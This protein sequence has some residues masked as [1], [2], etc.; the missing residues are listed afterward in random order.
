MSKLKQALRAH[1]RTLRRSSELHVSHFMVA[2]GESD[3]DAV[4]AALDLLAAEGT[5]RRRPWVECPR[6]GTAVSSDPDDIP[7]RCACGEPLTRENVTVHPTYSAPPQDHRLLSPEDGAGPGLDRL[8]A[9]ALGRTPCDGWEAVTLGGHGGPALQAVTCFHEEGACWPVREHMGLGGLPKYSTDRT[10]LSLA[11]LPADSTLRFDGHR[12]HVRVPGCVEVS[13]AT[14]PHA[15]CLAVVAAGAPPRWTDENRWRTGWRE[16]ATEYALDPDAPTTPPIAHA[17]KRHQKERTSHLY[18]LRRSAETTRR[19]GYVV[20]Q[21]AGRPDD[22]VR[23]FLQARV[24]ADLLER[25]ETM[26]KVEAEAR[27]ALFL[28]KG[29]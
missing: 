4:E 7:S 17:L 16:V 24:P 14:E 19:A 2:V 9:D 6:C 28:A 8:V 27:F 23:P 22:T 13:A 10:L 21:A 11:D 1:V 18:W 15:L 12:W 26:A 29:P 3:A 25:V 5:L 20:S